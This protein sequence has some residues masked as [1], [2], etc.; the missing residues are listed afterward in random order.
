MRAESFC[1]VV[2]ALAVFGREKFAALEFRMSVAYR[3]IPQQMLHILRSEQI[4]ISVIII[5]VYV[6]V[7]AKSQGRDLDKVGDVKTSAENVEDLIWR[8]T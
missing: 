6:N 3:F 4:G 2:N 8:L 5:C 7:V 1:V